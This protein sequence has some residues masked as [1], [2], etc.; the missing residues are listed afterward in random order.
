MLIRGFNSS[1]AACG[2]RWRHVAALGLEMKQKAVAETA[3]T[4]NCRAAGPWRSCLELG[5]RRLHNDVTHRGWRLSSLEA[6][7]NGCAHIYMA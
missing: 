4:L 1:M 5:R 6:R 3:V 7:G 2:Q